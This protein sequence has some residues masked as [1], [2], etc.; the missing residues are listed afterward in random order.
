M[1]RDMAAGGL[2]PERLFALARRRQFP[3]ATE[4][5]EQLEGLRMLPDPDQRSEI[6][7]LVR[8]GIGRQ[9]P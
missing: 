3:A 5:R 7:A 1:R 2:E 4:H 6:V 9:E 8:L